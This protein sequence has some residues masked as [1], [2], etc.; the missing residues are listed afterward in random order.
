LFTSDALEARDVLPHFDTLV[1]AA[2]INKYSK[3]DF[4]QVRSALELSSN[5]GQ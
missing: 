4:D 5:R 3:G 2:R 1:I